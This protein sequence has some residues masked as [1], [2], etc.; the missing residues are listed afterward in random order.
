M[1]SAGEILRTARQD[2]NLTLEEVSQRTKIRPKVLE[3]MERD[4]F[5]ILPVTYMQGFVKTYT[6]FLSIHELPEIVGVQHDIH[7]NGHAANGSHHNGNG[8]HSVRHSATTIDAEFIASYSYAT[9]P[10]TNPILKFIYGGVAL[11]MAAVGYVL[12]VGSPFGSLLGTP[13]NDKQNRLAAKPLQVGG[14]LP[15]DNTT[16]VLTAPARRDTALASGQTTGQDSII[17]EAQVI[18][19]A[20]ISMVIDKKNSKQ[21]T[22]E[23]GKT[24]R[25]AAERIFALSL[26]N[27]GGVRFRLNGRP[28]EPLGKSGSVVRD[29]KITRETVVSSS[30][31]AVAKN[32]RPET[33]GSPTTFVPATS[34]SP[35]SA[36]AP[37]AKPTIAPNIQPN[38][39]TAPLNTATK[40]SDSVRPKPRSMQKK[41]STTKLIEPA[42]RPI[43]P[44]E[45]KPLLNK[46]KLNLTQQPEVKRN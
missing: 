45:I 1:S 42:A 39:A 40:S 17:L 32:L 6:Q 33:M 9:K 46:A 31:P 18:E 30:T 5:G 14:D 29:V 19:S 16:L 20:W 13:S 44:P 38:T 8:V 4:E 35:N 36:A 10:R 25:W 12:L 24:Y 37:A 26:G 41:T 23:A 43:V 2:R 27:A 28:I 15:S 34:V 11:L 22:L 3:A 7:R 21:E